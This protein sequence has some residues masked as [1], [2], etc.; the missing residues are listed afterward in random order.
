VYKFKRHKQFRLPYYNYASSGLYFVTICTYHRKN[1]FG[2][3]VQSEIVLTEIGRYLEECI[4]NIPKKLDYVFIDDF[5]IMPNHVHVIVL[6]DNPDEEFA[7][8]EKEFR[9]RKR[10]LS[11][12]VRNLKSTVTLLARRNTLTK[13][14][15]H[16]RFYDR[17]I[18]NENELQRIRK[19]IRDNPLRWEEE[20][21]N[22][23]S[24]LM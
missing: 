23:E 16:S 7:L 5:V 8:K 3:I 15:W 1:L 22:S 13:S 19:Y 18:R 14:V 9:P 4:Q 12:V 10:S 20:K 24:L 21:N 17:I 11:I 2:E 6:I